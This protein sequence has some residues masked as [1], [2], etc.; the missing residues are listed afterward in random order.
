MK[1]DSR[2]KLA[3]VALAFT[4]A[5]S[6][7]TLA[8]DGGEKENPNTEFKFIGNVEDQPVFELNL[9]DNEDEYT[10]IFRDEIGNILYIDKFKGANGSKKFLLKS[11][12]LVDETLNVVVKSKKNNTTAVYKINRSASYVEETVINKVK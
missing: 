8:N 2:R 11:D 3:I 7:P 10:V 4:L 6:T 12:E 9:G 5:F 1:T